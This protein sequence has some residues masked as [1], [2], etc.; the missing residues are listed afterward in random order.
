MDGMVRL[1]RGLRPS[2]RLLALA[3]VFCA[4]FAVAGLPQTV[5]AQLPEGLIVEGIDG[6]DFVTGQLEARCIPNFIGYLVELIFGVVGLIC[7]INIMIAG[8]ELA[9]SGVTEDKT[10]GKN[11][12]TYSVIGA[13]VCVC[14]FLIVDFFI[15]AVFFG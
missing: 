7:L 2:L 8:Y 10:A 15:S 5:S 4:G 1:P 12:L 11:R 14:A 6:C 3:A 9:A 13:V